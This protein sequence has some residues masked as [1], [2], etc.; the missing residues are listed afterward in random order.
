MVDGEASEHGS[1]DLRTSASVLILSSTPSVAGMGC[2]ACQSHVRTVI[3]RS[4]GVV[5]SDVDFTKGTARLVVADG[6]GFDLQ[7]LSAR[8]A[9]EGYDVQPASPP[10]PPPPVVTPASEAE[11]KA[12]L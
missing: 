8:L 5:G 6:W 11:S 2:E 10:P 1:C 3:D 4:A 9:T 12:E 7:R